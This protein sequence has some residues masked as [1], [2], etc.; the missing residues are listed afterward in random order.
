MSFQ[1]CRCKCTCTFIALVVGLI[2]GVITAFLQITAAIAVTPVF[3]I[4]AFGI[5][6]GYLGIL[7]IASAL[8]VR[9]RETE[10]RCS[11]LNT[12]LTGILGTILVAVVLLLTGIIAT[13]VLSA[14]LIGA[15]VFFFTLIIAGSA[16]LV[17]VL[18][19]CESCCRTEA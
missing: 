7:V 17:R 9:S 6:V 19:G 18:T 11:S 15:L 10:C 5:A 2:L 3:L 1:N 8:A 4:A 12:V 14:I 16:C 13:S